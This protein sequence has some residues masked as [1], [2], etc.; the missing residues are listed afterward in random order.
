MSVLEKIK[1]RTNI[2]VEM[3][4]TRLIKELGVDKEQE[5]AVNQVEYSLYDTLVLILDVIH[6]PK[7]PEGLY[8]TWLRMTKDYWYLNGYNKLFENSA[9]GES[10]SDTN[11][12]VK[13]LQVGDTTTE[14]ADISSQVQINGVTYSTGTIEYSEDALIEKYKK[15]LYRHRKLRWSY[16]L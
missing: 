9:G 13:K 14:F 11:A 7:V 12:K 5:D 4:K 15:D 3:L 6:Q 10:N 1:N 8:T 16:G 2:D